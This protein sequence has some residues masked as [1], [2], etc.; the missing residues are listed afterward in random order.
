MELSYLY[1]LL[2]RCLYQVTK[3]DEPSKYGV[4]VNHEGTTCVQRFVEKPKEF[5]SNKIN[6][7]IYIFNPAIL[8]RIEVGSETFEKRL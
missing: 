2:I 7:G 5:V 4:V 3:V 1:S 8:D 6:A